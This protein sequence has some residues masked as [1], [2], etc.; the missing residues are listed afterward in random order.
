ME[1]SSILVYFLLRTN[2]K[3]NT[4]TIIYGLVGILGGILLAIPNTAT[5]AIA[6][7]LFF[8]KGVLDW[9]DGTLARITNQTSLR[10]RILDVYGAFLNSMGL[11]MGLGF[12]VAAKSNMVL[13]YYLIPLIPFFFA[14]GLT[15]Y[16][17]QILF[18]YIPKEKTRQQDLST[19]SESGTDDAEK[20]EKFTN[21]SL[22]DKL[23]FLTKVFDDRARSVD[24]ILLLILIEILFPSFF[25]TWI[26]FL[27][28]IVKA[29]IVFLG[30]FHLVVIEGWVE[31][32]MRGLEYESR[33][34]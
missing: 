4:I 1:L 31:K 32:N 9:S 11:Q 17:K 24:F 29:L 33:D 12:Y 7:F 14:A 34:T 6:L 21:R 27:V 20:G 10:G 28:L 23:R 15:N 18:E 22:V 8:S 26:I 3:P 25:I 19:V 13:F 30:K 2:I 16:A 5:I